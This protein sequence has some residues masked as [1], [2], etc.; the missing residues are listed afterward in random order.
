MIILML[1][2][3]LSSLITNWCGHLIAWK[4]FLQVWL[5]LVRLPS[6]IQDLGNLSRL[7]H[8]LME[9]RLYSLS[10]HLASF[11]NVLFQFLFLLSRK[12]TQLLCDL[13]QIYLIKK[14]PCSNGISFLQNKRIWRNFLRR[15]IHDIYF[16]DS[17]KKSHFYT[18]S[19]MCFSFQSSWLDQYATVDKHF[20]W[21]MKNIYPVSLLQDS[22]TKKS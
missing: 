21:L 14:F 4:I 5:D 10:E 17:L 11:C 15:E 19:I 12:K 8:H 18:D 16:P 6:L 22:T 20:H 3:M 2:L 13:L 1:V 9:H 7:D